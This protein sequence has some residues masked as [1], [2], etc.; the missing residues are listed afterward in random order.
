[1]SKR[2][3]LLEAQQLVDQRQEKIV[4]FEPEDDELE[5]AYDKVLDDLHG[6][7]WPDCLSHVRPSTVIKEYD[8]VGY[9]TGQGDWLDGEKDN[10]RWRE[11]FPSFKALKDELDEAELEVVQLEADVQELEDRLVELED[12]RAD[13]EGARLAA[14][15]DEIADVKSEL[16]G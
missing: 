10:R 7:Q 16:G 13:A 3:E 1:M 15:D 8:A 14:I 11:G 6:E 9:R 5:E 4:D 2:Q 12:E